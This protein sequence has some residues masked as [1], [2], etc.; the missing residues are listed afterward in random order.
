MSLVR[1]PARPFSSPRLSSWLEKPTLMLRLKLNRFYTRWI[2]PSLFL[3]FL[4]YNTEPDTNFL[5]SPPFL[6]NSIQIEKSFFF[7]GSAE[8]FSCPQV[9]RTGEVRWDE[10]KFCVTGVS[11]K[12]ETTAN[13]MLLTLRNYNPP[14]LSAVLRTVG[15]I[16][17]ERALLRSSM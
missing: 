4:C 3:P 13:A 15:V 12:V 9:K 8:A 14:A 17:R 11:I 5:N 16:S 6:E 2:L 1:L 7:H 10:M